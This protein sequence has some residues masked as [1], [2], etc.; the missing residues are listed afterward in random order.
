MIVCLSAGNDGD[1]NWKYVSVPADADSVITIGAVDR[2]GR[3]ASFSSKGYTADRRIKPDLVA[4]G[5]ETAYQST[6]GNINT[7]NGTS[8]STPLLA[9]LMACLWQAHPQKSNME[10]MDMVK[11]SASHFHEPDSLYGY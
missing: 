3:Y 4:M 1:T 10:I 8:Y 9:G 5:R 6:M 2:E 11:R 7:G